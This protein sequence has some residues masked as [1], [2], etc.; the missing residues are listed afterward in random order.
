M[1]LQDV[2]PGMKYWAV[3]ADRLRAAQLGQGNGTVTGND[4]TADMLNT[5]L[6]S[7]AKGLDADRSSWPYALGSPFQEDMDATRSQTVELYRSWIIAGR[8]PV[9]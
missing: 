4:Y 6:L 3:C 9:Q 1:A 8:P 2:G 7:E 5:D